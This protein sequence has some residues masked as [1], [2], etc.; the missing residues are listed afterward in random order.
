MHSV[1]QTRHGVAPLWYQH[2]E[3]GGR[4][5]LCCIASWRPTWNTWDPF[6]KKKKYDEGK[7]KE[8]S[9]SRGRGFY[10][11]K[12]LLLLIFILLFP[13][14]GMVV[15]FIKPEAMPNPR[16]SSNLSL[17]HLDLWQI[18]NML[19]VKYDGSLLCTTPSHSGVFNWIT[20]RTQSWGSLWRTT[21]C[22]QAGTALKSPSPN[23]LGIK[24]PRLWKWESW[25]SR[26]D[27]T[28][29]PACETIS[30]NFREKEEVNSA[31]DQIHS[32]VCWLVVCSCPQKSLIESTNFEVLCMVYNCKVC[33]GEESSKCPLLPVPPVGC[34]HWGAWVSGHSTGIW[35][36][37]ASMPLLRLLC[38]LG[39]E[40]FRVL[41]WLTDATGS[42]PRS[43]IIFTVETLF[44]SLVDMRLGTHLCKTPSDF[45]SV[46]TE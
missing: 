23:S 9:A 25:V 29:D 28:C 27:S 31:S 40:L 7:K 32:F 12:L 36:I 13:I 8:G 34:V 15:L 21:V 39:F 20:L 44:L 11:F 33:P 17:G 45:S 43:F 24:C 26:K 5:A 6:S 19:M 22:P 41:D 18:L 3:G 4:K 38:Y 14:I 46:L 10:S 30:D 2:L 1:T 42:V 35:V 16:Q 37:S